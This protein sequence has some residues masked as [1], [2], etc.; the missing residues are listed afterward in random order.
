MAFARAAVVLLAAAA[1]FPAARAVPL[2]GNVIRRCSYHHH[3][4]RL[5]QGHH[6]VAASRSMPVSVSAS[7][8]YSLSRRASSSGSP[9]TQAERRLQTSRFRRLKTHRSGSNGNFRVEGSIR[10]RMH[11]LNRMF[12]T[13]KPKAVGEDVDAMRNSLVESEEKLT[14]EMIR[15]IL[16]AK[17]GREY[18]V[19]LCKRRDALGRKKV[20]FQIMWKFLGQR[21]FM[22]EA[23]Y[24]AQLTAVAE[25]INEWGVA[26]DV[27]DG[28][29]AVKIR[30]KMDTAGAHA[31]MIPLDNVDADVL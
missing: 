5:P 15:M 7:L 2:P 23:A 31:V 16:K 27:L 24:V 6:A 12:S 26:S 8:P 22:S 25:K 9:L 29:E 4:N 21:G 14:A 19:R 30:P 13:S 28:I 3:N 1:V 10:Q 18:D 20:Y 11:S 17:Y